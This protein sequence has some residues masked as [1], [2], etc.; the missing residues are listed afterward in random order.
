MS[1]PV[2][3]VRDM[4]FEGI[5]QVRLLFGPGG[6]MRVN[7]AGRSGMP[8][9]TVDITWLAE[10]LCRAGIRLRR[11]VPEP[12]SVTGDVEGELGGGGR[13]MW[14][15]GGGDI[16]IAEVLWAIA[17]ALEQLPIA[18]IIDIADARQ[19]SANRLVLTAIEG[20]LEQAGL[21]KRQISMLL[22]RPRTVLGGRSAEQLFD[23]VS[24]TADEAR[25]VVNLAVGRVRSL[26]GSAGVTTF[27]EAMSA[28]PA[29]SR[30][31]K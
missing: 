8:A 17:A 23:Q 12:R 20:A 27:L 24:M 1:H 5:A 29:V 30:R 13:A 14:V 21:T 31:A 28:D 3:K 16:N 19:R 11:A 9:S 25:Q 4:T 22:R 6:F 26:A 2:R 15:D 10:D 7:R 18:E